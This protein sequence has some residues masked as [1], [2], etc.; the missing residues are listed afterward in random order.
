MLQ[1][2]LKIKWLVMIVVFLCIAVKASAWPIN[3]TS[4]D[5]LQPVSFNFLTAEADAPLLLFLP[6][7][8][9][10]PFDDNIPGELTNNETLFIGNADNNVSLLQL[11]KSMKLKKILRN[12]IL[13]QRFYSTVATVS[14]NMGMYPFAMQCYYQYGVDADEGGSNWLN[15]EPALLQSLDTIA[16]SVINKGQIKWRKNSFP[17]KAIEIQEAFSDGKTALACALILHIK[18]PVPGRRRAFAGLNNVGHTF[19]TLIKYNTDKSFVSRSFGFYPAKDDLFSATPLQPVSYSVI[20]NDA[21]HN[22]DEVIGKFISYRRLLKTLRLLNK[23]D[24]KKY[25]LNKNNCTD[26]GLY[27]AI[28]SGIDVQDTKGNWPLG[29]GNNPGSIGQSILEKKYKNTD[30]TGNTGGLFICNN[31]DLYKR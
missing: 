1:Q 20:K 14:A 13:R 26:F 3:R 4:I 9:R 6:L 29:K 16:G 12:T 31:P 24:N 21:F 23:F 17:V 25:H 5:S 19:I 8:E 10:E 15:D 22:W 18:Q 27:A 11:L 2:V 7:N 30:D 28:I